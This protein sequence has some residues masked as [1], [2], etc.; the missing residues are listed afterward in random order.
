[1]TPKTAR[2][3]LIEDMVNLMIDHRC[4]DLR[5]RIGDVVV[6]TRT[7]G[8]FDARPKIEA[9]RYGMLVDMRRIDI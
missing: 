9:P 5:A 8:M 6:T 4:S 1:M 3:A 2:E 7:P